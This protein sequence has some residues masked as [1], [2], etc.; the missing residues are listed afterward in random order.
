MSPEERPGSD[1]QIQSR[2][3]SFLPPQVVE[4]LK[5]AARDAAVHSYSPYSKFPVGAAVLAE[6][7]HIYS[8]T[9]VENSSYGLTI[10]A[11]RAAVFSAVSVGERRITALAVYT[12]TD[13]PSVPCGACLAV[14]SEFAEGEVPILM[15][16][17]EK[18][19]WST[20]DQLLPQRFKLK[21]KETS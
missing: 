9:N 16:T 14:I 18:Q 3:E 11:E 6:S 15:F 2:G 8:G 12:P 10:C 1:P 21:P 19:R 20:L 7:G 13:E 17:E 4:N 5:Q